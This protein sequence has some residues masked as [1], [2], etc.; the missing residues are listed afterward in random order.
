MNNLTSIRTTATGVV[1]ILIGLGALG[2]VLNS[3][4]LGEPVTYEQFAV[5]IGAIVLGAQGV[6]ARDNKTTSE[7]VFGAK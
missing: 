2:N 5:A 1:A 6:F 3:F 7:Q 4:L